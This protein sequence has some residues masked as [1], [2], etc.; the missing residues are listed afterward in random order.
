M[1]P[2]RWRRRQP[3]RAIHLSW[4]V[5]PL[6]PHGPMLEAAIGV[7]RDAFA[8]PPYNDT[9]RATEV[10]DRLVKQHAVQ[11]G[12]RSLAA[13]RADGRVV[14]MTYGHNSDPGQWWHDAAA[15][16]ITPDHYRR[17][18]RGGYEL[19]EIAVAPDCQSQGIGR[20]LIAA[21]LDGVERSACVLSTRTDSRAHE[22]YANL[23]FQT[24]TEMRFFPTGYPFYVMGRRLR[25]G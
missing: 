3:E 2:M 16:V 20:A 9:G 24:L 7:Y 23:G 10:R 1:Q 22:L 5:Q 13:V 18:F 19:V 25:P 14:G 8:R 15:A 4:S 17:F 21:L 6:P 12:F 11:A